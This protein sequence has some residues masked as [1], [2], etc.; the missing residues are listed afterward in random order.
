M[1]AVSSEQVDEIVDQALH[2]QQSIQDIEL[3]VLSNGQTQHEHTDLVQAGVTETELQGTNN[4]AINNIGEQTPAV[5]RYVELEPADY[6]LIEP[7]E[8]QEQVDVLSLDTL[9]EDTAV[10]E[11]QV[12]NVA[13]GAAEVEHKSLFVRLYEA[14]DASEMPPLETIFE[15]ADEVPVEKTLMAIIATI[16]AT[17]DLD[18]D[19]G[20]AI[21]LPVE[22]E[23][24]I[25]EL[26]EIL[27]T[28]ETSEPLLQQEEVKSA[29]LQLLIAVG[30][31]KPQEALDAF[32]S[33]YS[34]ELLFEALEHICKLQ[35][36]AKPNLTFAPTVTIGQS[37]QEYIA[38]FFM[39][40]IGV[41][42]LELSI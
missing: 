6:E 30:Y 21:V 40:L 17:N 25:N 15:E 10:L 42:A 19:T 20:E 27:Q 34:S 24:A 33:R 5:E 32:V 11:D 29:V 23:D 26:H 13:T 7:D 37:R 3:K 36:V 9:P 2:V 18:T 38:R 1:R 8:T 28:V 12:V 39:S 31:V 41:N 4:E 16:E 35:Q 14:T 22:I